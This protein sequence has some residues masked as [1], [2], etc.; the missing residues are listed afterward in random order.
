MLN[1]RLAARVSCACGILTTAASLPAQSPQPGAAGTLPEAPAAQSPESAPPFQT[2]T[3]D[4]EVYVSREELAQEEITAEEKQRVLGVFPNFYTSYVW[5]AT[6]LS[7]K[8][9]FELAGRSSIDP[10]NIA[11]AGITAGAQQS[12]NDLS[13]YGQGAAGYGRRFGAD[14]GGGVIGAFVGGAAL[15]SLLHQ[16]PR[17]F[18]K[19]TGSGFSRTMY[20]ISRTVVT[21]GDN[22]RWQPNYSGIL[23][24]LASGGIADLYY[25]ES[26]R[27]G[28]G[29]IFSNT[30]I[31]LASG[32]GGNLLQE[33]VI[34]HFTPHL[35]KQPPPQP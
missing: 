34:R 3:T 8:Q 11:I 9:K 27:N 5:N 31:G 1:L 16:D 25:P 23:G 15:P 12:A 19:G 33:F 22:G 14:Y 17:Y 24:S 26:D 20:A 35:P 10:V 18:Y 32:A 4:I 21:R 7:T 30:A 13:G 2:Q 29:T 6:P 28:A